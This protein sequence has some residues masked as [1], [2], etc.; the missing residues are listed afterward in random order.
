[1]AVIMTEHGGSNLAIEIFDKPPIWEAFCR[2]LGTEY[3]EGKEIVG[4]SGITHSVQAIGVD[5]KGQRI[6]LVSGEYNPRIAALMRIDVQAT[7]PG[8]RVLV[9]RPL[10]LDLAYAARK[11]FFT[12][13]G[14]LDISKILQ[15]GAI[16]ESADG[17]EEFLKEHY[18]PPTVAIFGSM[19][20][21]KLP[22]KSHILNLLE[23]LTS[24]DWSRVTPPRKKENWLQTAV[25]TL[26]QFSLMDNLAADR[27]QG[28]CPVPTYELTD[29]D[30][31]LFHNNKHLDEIQ[32][33]LKELSIY[34]Y[35]FPP[36]DSFALGLID[37]GL[38]TEPQIA[39]GM[40]LAQR[41]GH[42]LSKN[43]LIS[44][45]TELSDIIELLKA[46]GYAM[47]G[48]LTM[49]LTEEGKAVRQ[50]VKVRPSEGLFQKVSRIMSVKV[51]LNLK[52]LF[53]H[54]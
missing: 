26:T 1:M 33:R 30:W 32:A 7:L 4:A 47:E 43:T 28:I 14:T 48:E 45:A 41:E 5:E 50:T 22:V 15:L 46:S 6:V 44:D 20:R 18:G 9:A 37:N 13:A 10:A 27:A 17:A 38:A 39:G 53:G 11:M 8:T 19:A 51:D 12:D 40:D 52:D 24:M 34:Q 31:D 3:R 54:K 36:A 35:F 16:L 21:S 49:E 25:D 2:A 42:Q 29:S 23:Q